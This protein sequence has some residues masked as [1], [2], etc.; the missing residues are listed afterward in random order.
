MRQRPD[1]C[2]CKDE[3]PDPCPACGATVEGA[4]PVRGVCQARYGYRR[5]PDVL[6]VLTHRDTGEV[7]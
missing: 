6:L 7:I 4:D 5:E 2:P 1:Y 3:T